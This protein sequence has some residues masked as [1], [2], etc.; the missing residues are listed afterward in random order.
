MNSSIIGKN[1]RRIRTEKGL[2]R[3]TVSKKLGFHHVN[4][5]YYIEQGRIN[6]VEKDLEEICKVLDC[7]KEELTNE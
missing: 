6:F 5:L 4:L 7:N 3:W 2:K 1:I